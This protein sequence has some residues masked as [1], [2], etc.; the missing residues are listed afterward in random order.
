MR[1]IA[2]LVAA[3]LPLAGCGSADPKEPK[4]TVAPTVTATAAAPSMPPEAK[5]KTVQGA[6]EFV[7]FYV[8]ILNF[9]AST[10]NTEKLAAI[11][12]PDCEGCSTYIELYRTTYKNG[13]FYQNSKWHLTGI[14]P[15]T[16]EGQPLI[17]AD[18]HIP[19]AIFKTGANEPIQHGKSE[20][21]KLTFVPR[22]IGGSWHLKELGLQAG[23]K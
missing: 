23:A 9:A 5:D 8:E 16:Q 15:D 12:D 7:R 20:D 1:I 6:A 21:S 14:R 4:P 22:L 10:G 3:A 13:G 2:I 17:F 19:A 18:V 11:S